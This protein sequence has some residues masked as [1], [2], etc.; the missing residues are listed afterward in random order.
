MAKRKFQNR[1]KKVGKGRWAIAALVVS[2]LLI[3][4]GILFIFP[5]FTGNIIANY[6]N[7]T[8]GGTVV[9]NSSVAGVS[10]IIAGIIGLFLFSR[11]K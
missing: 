2:L 8:G 7:S 11:K 5:L 6:T 1:A 9:G 3:I 10:L 4:A